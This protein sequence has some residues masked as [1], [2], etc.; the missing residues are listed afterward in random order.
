MANYYFNNAVSENWSDL[1]NWWLDDQFSVP[2]TQLPTNS[3]TVYNPNYN[4]IN[5][6]GLNLSGFDLS[7][8]NFSNF[9]I[10]NGSNNFSNAN[11]TNVTFPTITSSNTNFSGANLT[12][13]T[14][15]YFLANGQSGPILLNFSN[16]NL[17]NA[18]LA[19]P[20]GSVW[21]ATFYNA[22]ISNTSGIE[23]FTNNA[24][25]DGYPVDVEGTGYFSGVFYINNVETTLNGF[26]NGTWNDLYYESGSLYTG[27]NSD[28]NI[29]YIAGV[30]TTLDNN[31]SGT[32]ND[33]YY[34]SGSLYTGFS[35]PTYYIEGQVTEL[36]STGTGTF[37]GQTY[38]NGVLQG[39][40][41]SS[42]LKIT[43]GANVKFLGKVKVN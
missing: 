19:V 30:A 9:D 37:N 5:A 11:L 32:W 3:D 22:I 25:S 16:A 14:F 6:S 41:S 31:G 20:D 24:S 17:T 8:F 39:G 15:T 29:Y 4:T 1:G 42:T 13:A 7:T 28:N 18:T 23:Y 38:I 40:G 27:F 21:Q 43:T 35:D 12:G 2:A 26:G 33:L 10:G 36:D 34:E